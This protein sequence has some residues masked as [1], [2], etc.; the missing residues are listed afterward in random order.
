M[1]GIIY[2]GAGNIFS[3]SAA[4]QRLHIP[5]KVITTAA[6]MDTCDRFIIPGVGHAAQA[7]QKLHET[8]LTTHILNTKKPVLG[9]CLGMQLLSTFSEEGQTSLLNV[10][11]LHTRKFTEKT[12]KTPHMGWNTMSFSNTEPLFA[13]ISPNAYFYFVHSYFIE[14]NTNFTIGKC[15]YGI[16]FSAAIHSTNFYGVQFH[17]EKSGKNGEQVLRNFSTLS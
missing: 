4:L 14:F 2:Y 13:H 1:L 9:I 12:L 17:P 10:V 7:M 5:F 16:P 11:P 8:G 6:E 3:L 15:E